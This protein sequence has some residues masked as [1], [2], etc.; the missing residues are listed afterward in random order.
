MNVPFMS[1]FS[2]AF[3]NAALLLRPAKLSGGFA[4]PDRAKRRR[5]ALVYPSPTLEWL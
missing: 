2:N 1:N 4:G 5:I 3:R